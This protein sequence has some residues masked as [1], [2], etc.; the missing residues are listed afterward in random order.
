M[1]NHPSVATEATPVPS[2]DVP[3][4]EDVLRVA[5]FTHE[6]FVC[7]DEVAAEVLAPGTMRRVAFDLALAELEA[8]AAEPSQKWR[9]RWSMLLGLD[10]TLHHDEP[11]LA[12]G[13]TLNP[14]QV[15][16]LSGTYAALLADAQRRAR[17][18]GD[19]DDELVLS[20]E[21]PPAPEPEEE[22]APKA[23][24][25]PAEEDE[26]EDDDR[27]EDPPDAEEELEELPELDAATAAKLDSAYDDEGEEDVDEDIDQLALDDPNAH[28]RFWFEHATGAGK[29]VAAMGFVESCRS[30]G[31]LIL[32]HRRNLVDQFIAELRD[33]GYGDRLSKPLLGDAD[34]AHGPVTIETY[35]WFVR[36]A[37]QISG[38]YTVVICDEAHTALG[39]K[40]S[41]AI[42]AWTG[43]IFIGMT[44]TGALI[45]RHVTDLFPTQTSRFDLAQA[46]RRGVIAPLRALRIPPGPGVRT[47]A[48][49]P[50]RKGEVDME[51]DQ[52]ELAKLLD[53]VPFNLAIADL[54]R[55]RFRNAPGVVYAAGVQHAYNVAESFRAAGMKAEAVSGETNKRELAKILAQYEAGEIDVLV[56]AQLLAEGWNSPRAT[57]CMHLAPTASKRIYQQRVGRVTRRQ[58]GKEAGVVVD[59]VH[60]ATTH[61]DPVVTLHS[62]L[63]RDVYR[64]GAIVVGPVRRGRG[65]RVK[66]ERRVLPVTPDI[67]RRRQVFERELWRIAVEQ[68]DWGEQRVWAALAGAKASPTNWRRARAMLNFD[69]SGELRRQ[70]LVTAL[71]RNRNPQLRLRAVQEI[72]TLKEAEPFDTAID[73]VGQWPRDERREASRILLQ[74]MADRRIGRRDQATAWIWRLAEWTRDLHEEYAAQ[75]WPATKHLLGLLVNSSGA[76]HARNARR[77]VHAARQHDRRLQAAL[78]AAAVAHTPEAEEV[79]REARTRLARKP[80]ALSRDLLKDFP[81]GK[82]R[83]KRPRKK[84]GGGEGAEAT[85]E[86]V[87]TG[88][89]AATGEGTADATASETTATAE[90]GQGKRRR[91]RRRGGGGGAASGASA[92]A[93]AT[94]EAGGDA[95]TAGEDRAVGDPS[96][97]RAAPVAADGAPGDDAASAV[98]ADAVSASDAAQPGTSVDG[99]PARRTR[100]GAAS[101]S[102]RTSTDEVASDGRVATSD[103]D[104]APKRPSRARAAAVEAPSE[105]S[106]GPDDRPPRRTRA[107]RAAAETDASSAD[108]TTAEDAGATGDDQAATRAR[109]VAPETASDEAPKPKRTSRTRKAAV[110]APAE[111]SAGPDDAPPRRTRRAASATSTA[112]DTASA[113]EDA[114][115]PKGR[116]TRSRKAATADEDA[117]PKGRATRA[118]KAATAAADDEAAPKAAR[119]PRTRKAATPDPDGTDDAPPK[120]TRTRKAAADATAT[121]DATAPKRA[122]RTRRATAAASD[123]DD[124]APAKRPRRTAAAPDA[125]DASPAPRS[126]TRTAGAAASEAGDEA[127]AP[128]RATRTRK[129]AAADAPAAASAA[130]DDAPPKRTRARKATADGPASGD[131]TAAPKRAARTRKTTSAEDD[132]PAP[133]RATRTR[134]TASTEDDA[135]APK[136]A[137]RARKAPATDADAPSA[138]GDAPAGRPRKAPASKVA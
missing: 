74:A 91:R 22:P 109:A 131:E 115:A 17:G 2:R 43:P 38:A 97:G 94:A 18:G 68:L 82:K 8:G 1:A 87:A 9:R 99:A 56:N 136:R 95:P 5:A 44:A 4:H 123:A 36:N 10:R 66:V 70:F 104:A 130:P 98:R 41:A 113:G 34:D 134:K 15:D 42:R 24:E 20:F 3:S 62:L 63:D 69:R 86:A 55:T 67:E 47:I 126:R 100:R 60:P 118:R 85:T 132:A 93:T 19:E 73:Q 21:E 48:K 83:K 80:G 103:V 46:A 111:A 88:A 49:V 26:D 25:V 75:R 101:G 81:K 61:D 28:K 71:E 129:V 92:D 137:T 59:F 122:T 65:R 127:A 50:L 12:D 37:G 102:P 125:D 72:A 31:I 40:T 7:D 138:E 108:A 39:D 53:Q 96:P 133:K 78:L 76:A 57:V 79:L 29:T 128:K 11:A 77:L 13:T 120:R 107:R 23:A 16:A 116:A 52:D 6:P 64:G 106:A 119:T 58:P 54:Y 51:F 33:R 110:E 14:H 90:P 121:A 89:E 45:A 30:G 32:T 135:P 114:A 124:D 105:A 84:K 35:Q 117:A 112:D 27:D